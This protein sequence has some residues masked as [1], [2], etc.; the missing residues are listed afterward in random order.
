[1]FNR[2]ETRRHDRSSTSVVHEHRAPTDDSIRLY[3]ELQEKARAAI[4]ETLVCKDNAFAFTCILEES[5][6]NQTAQ[7]TLRY[8]LDGVIRTWTHEIDKL[9]DT[10]ETLLQELSRHVAT[11]ILSSAMRKDDGLLAQMFRR[12]LGVR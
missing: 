2:Y 11:T 4:L 8:S 5:P 10:P 6:L 7:F 12:A 1:M 9:C 3:K